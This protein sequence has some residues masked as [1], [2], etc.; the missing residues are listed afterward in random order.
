MNEVTVTRTA[1]D[2]LVELAKIAALKD[3]LKEREQVIRASL[4]AK[5]R[6]FA[7]ANDMAPTLRVK[8]V[9]S[10]YLTDPAEVPRVTDEKAWGRWCQERYPSRTGSRISV[11]AARVL[12]L[13]E[14]DQGLERW[15]YE[16]MVL[17]KE[18]LLEEGLTYELSQ[19]LPRD[20]HNQLVDPDT[21][22]VLPVV[23][24]HPRSSTFT[25]RIDKAV[26]EQFIA[27]LM[28]AR[29]PVLDEGR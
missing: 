12:E 18:P 22:E 6:D 27:E 29:I 28:R 20:P 19:K 10:A 17:V 4:E 23:V 14:K 1:K 15:F 3:L 26:K 25:V 21:G 13:A 7:Q 9:G 8:D 16:E 5:A 11:D 2:E 24:E